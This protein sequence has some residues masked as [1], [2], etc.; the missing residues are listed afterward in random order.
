MVV[1]ADASPFVGLIKIEC[2]HILPGLFGSVVVPPEVLA[3]L[4]K[5][6]QAEEVR[7]FARSLPAWLTVHIAAVI[8]PIADLDRGEVAAIS[9]AVQLKADVLLI[10]ET[11]GRAA[12]MARNIPTFRTAAVIKQAADLGLIDNLAAAFGRLRQTNF[13]VPPSALD[14]LL[15]DHLRRKT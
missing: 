14:A 11:K 6:T 5:T 10:D 4:L 2:V 9:L 1:V 12:A 3:E 13:R 15:E 8:E 7:S